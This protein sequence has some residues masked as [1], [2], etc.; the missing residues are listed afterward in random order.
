MDKGVFK[1]NIFSIQ[2]KRFGDLSS[3]RA[4]VED[5]G[6]ALRNAKRPTIA[7]RLPPTASIQMRIIVS[8]KMLNL[9]WCLLTYR[10]A[11]DKNNATLR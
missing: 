2:I 6:Q 11:R 4:T 7:Y 3:S 1:A 5:I 10:L 8:E 9:F